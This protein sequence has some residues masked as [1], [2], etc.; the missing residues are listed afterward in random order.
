MR[1]RLVLLR[2]MFAI[3][4]VVPLVSFLF[5][6]S[7]LFLSFFYGISASTQVVCS[8]KVSD[9]AGQSPFV[10]LGSPH[11][12]STTKQPLPNHSYRL[13]YISF[14][15]SHFL[16]SLLDGVTL[17]PIMMNRPIFQKKFAHER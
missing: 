10:H 4:K 16:L 15:P 7:F 9:E 12:H 17:T 6:L 3:L 14:S 11:S 2:A 1:W 5:Y 8:S 13:P